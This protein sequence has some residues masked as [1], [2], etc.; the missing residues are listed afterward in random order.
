M[1][2]VRDLVNTSTTKKVKGLVYSKNV[3]SLVR[4][5]MRATHRSLQR[6]AGCAGRETNSAADDPLAQLLA[7]ERDHLAQKKKVFE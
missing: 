2:R 4:R 1:F 7:D 5:G 3:V 6:L